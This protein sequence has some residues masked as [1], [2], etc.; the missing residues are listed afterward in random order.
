M[1]LFLPL[2]KRKLERVLREVEVYDAEK[3][4]K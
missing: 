2:A 3:I 1:M 4:T